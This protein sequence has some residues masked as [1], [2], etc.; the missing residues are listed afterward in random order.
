M[1]LWPATFLLLV[2][3]R[4]DGD[5]QRS[6]PAAGRL[7]GLTCAALIVHAGVQAWIESTLPATHGLRAGWPVAY[8]VLASMLLWFGF[9]ARALVARDPAWRAPST[10][11]TERTASLAP[12]HLNHPVPRGAWMVG[13]VV[14]GACAAASVWAVSEGVHP[15][16]LLGLGWWFM[17]LFGARQAVL[18]PEPRD[19]LATPELD[20]SYARLRV[21][22]AWC[23]FGLG[24][25]GT[26]C[27]AGVAL[28]T[29][30]RPASAG[31]TGAVI[32]STLGIAG[33]V[34]GTVASVRKARAH[35]MLLDRS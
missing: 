1:V 32:G 20:A 9:G 7:L 10:G 15:A 13:W 24:L 19:R 4:P 28:L 22:K 3:P 26:V 29:A 16:L 11:G 31:I 21:F 12:R 5:A 23:F 27:F 14:F 17:A 18:E 2:R 33:A 35:R 34:F 30:V 25:A 8:A 6:A